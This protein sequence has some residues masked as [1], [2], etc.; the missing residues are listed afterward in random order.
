MGFLIGLVIQG[1]GNW[2]SRDRNLILGSRHLL[3][4][5]ISL[6]YFRS[7]RDAKRDFGGS[8][9]RMLWKLSGEIPRTRG[10][11]L[12]VYCGE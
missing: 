7:A 6:K 1:L 2:S 3:I 8:L 5:G 10:L 12:R 11:R 4:L 9:V